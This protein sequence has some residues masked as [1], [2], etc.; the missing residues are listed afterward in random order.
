MLWDSPL[1]DPPTR[2]WV[3]LQGIRFSAS[4]IIVWCDQKI[5]LKSG[6]NTPNADPL[7]ISNTGA[8]SASISAATD[9]PAPANSSPS[10]PPS[11][12]IRLAV[13]ASCP[14]CSFKFNYN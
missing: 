6:L 5:L 9:S 1:F 4:E 2:A 3:R 12:T 11:A 13:W 7:T 14:G 10:T 8:Q